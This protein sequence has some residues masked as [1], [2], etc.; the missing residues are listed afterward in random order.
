ML[1][2]LIQICFWIK[3]NWNQLKFFKLLFKFIEWYKMP[4]RTPT[5]TLKKISNIVLIFFIILTMELC[6]HQLVDLINI[7]HKKTTT[8]TRMLIVDNIII[9]LWW[10][11]SSYRY[12]FPSFRSYRDIVVPAPKLGMVLRRYNIILLNESVLKIY[13]YYLMV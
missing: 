4:H 13:T 7:K 5:R 8:T 2:Y 3:R 6:G 1:R 12:N 9:M 10:I 11:K